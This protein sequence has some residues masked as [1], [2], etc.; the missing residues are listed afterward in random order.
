MIEINI[1]EKLYICY[2]YFF[3]FFF[4]LLI[5]FVSYLATLSAF[6]EACCPFYDDTFLGRLW[7][8]YN[9]DL[10]YFCGNFSDFNK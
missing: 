9:E 1:Y 8:I 7:I 5:Q 3:I 2:S 10:F 6:N 4:F